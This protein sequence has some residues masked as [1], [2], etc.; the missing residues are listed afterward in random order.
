MFFCKLNTQP[1]SSGVLW[2]TPHFAKKRKK[3]LDIFR[4]GVYS[5]AELYLLQTKERHG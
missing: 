1:V 4:P 5:I 3:C 2:A